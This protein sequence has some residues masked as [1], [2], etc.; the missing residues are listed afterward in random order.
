MAKAR[1][2]HSNGRRYA[3]WKSGIKRGLKSGRYKASCGRF[4]RLYCF[5]AKGKP[6]ACTGYGPKRKPTAKSFRRT[7]SRCRDKATGKF[8]KSEFCPRSC[9]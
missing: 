2:K 5:T 4:S 8:V 9:K 1:R 7:I 3:A 6:T